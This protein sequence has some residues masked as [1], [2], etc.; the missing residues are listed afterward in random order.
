MHK[1]ITFG[2]DAR[3]KLKSG[4]DKLADTVKVTL[5]PKGRNVIIDKNYT[6]P[7]VT[8]DGVTVAEAIILNDRLENIGSTMLKDIAKKTVDEAGDGTTTSI[9]LA[10]AIYE[11]G[12]REIDNY[13]NNA[14]QI[15]RAVNSAV[16]YV[17]ERIRKYSNQI[18]TEND[19]KSIAFIS[20]NGD[21]NISDIVGK[22]VYEAGPTGFIHIKNHKEVDPTYT[23][24]EFV[25]GMKYP[26]GYASWYFCNNP[27]KQIC[28]FDNPLVLVSIE[29]ISSFGPIEFFV[30]HAVAENRPIVI[31]TE[32]MV[33]EAMA[34][35]LANVTRGKLSACVVNAP[36]MSNQRKELLE[37]I[38]VINKAKL[39]GNITGY[40]FI[41]QNM[42]V[43]ML[44]SCK[45]VVIDR[46]TITFFPDDTR[47]DKIE[48]RINQIKEHR[49]LNEGHLVKK[50]FDERIAILEGKIA[51][52]NFGGH[53]E[54]EIK[55]RID[56]V[57]D[58]VRATQSA[59]AEGTCEGGG[60]TY[61]K[62]AKE[63]DEVA[64]TLS[65]E[66]KIGYQIV[67]NSLR[68]PFKQIAYNS[69][70]VPEVIQQE[71][72]KQSLGYDFRNDVYCDLTN[73]GIIDPAKVLRV[74]LENASSI[75]SL[76]LTS[77]AIITNELSPLDLELLKRPKEMVGKSYE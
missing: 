58:A 19:L 26:S 25:D 43:D 3:E 4:I 27:D 1:E 36:G 66:Y 39:M 60:Y 64:N 44:G 24:Y 61:L 48:Q 63:L 75:A 71:M 62:I 7:K 67:A 22:V 28:E 2:K 74:A 40:P 70:L 38:A 35:L 41:P 52:L 33:G 69:G 6:S 17:T 77:E 57:D 15:Q 8:K 68:K 55:E 37:D 54:A 9:V 16:H 32:E 73:A 10:Q 76:L 11:E 31:M 34:T 65:N 59:F 53:T 18:E 51:S 5:G 45:K 47:K 12:L 23:G 21:T 56:R 42:K 29:K 50:K 30:R 20:S 49:N 14:I 46:N 13:K 72:E